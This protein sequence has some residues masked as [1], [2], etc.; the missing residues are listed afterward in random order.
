MADVIEMIR[1][2]PERMAAEMGV[3]L[4]AEDL[5]NMKVDPVDAEETPIRRSNRMK[6]DIPSS[7][8]SSNED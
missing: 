4:S 8:G 3:K 5:K 2:D 1:Q 6:L 7:R